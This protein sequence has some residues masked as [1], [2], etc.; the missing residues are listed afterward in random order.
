MTP[1]QTLVSQVTS[2]GSQYSNTLAPATPTVTTV[3][4][5]AGSVVAIRV[6]NLSASPVYL[7]MFDVSGSITL[8]STVA[9]YQFPVP[10][11]TAGAGIS[12]PLG[13][14]RSHANSIKFA[15]TGGIAYTD[16]TAIA[17]NSVIVDVSY[18]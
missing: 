10:G 5:S 12:I 1:V 15:V 14:L 2:G 7:K 18:N 13:E 4:S 9:N 6:L 16:S 17:G 3:K 8:G 11:S